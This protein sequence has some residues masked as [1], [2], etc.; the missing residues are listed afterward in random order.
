MSYCRTTIV[1]FNSEKDA[2]EAS[3]DYSKN[4]T[5]EFPDAEILLFTRTGHLSAVVSSVYP[6]DETTYKEMVARKARMEKPLIVGKV[7]GCIK[8]N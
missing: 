6:D 3:A 2:D 4:A 5:S 1:E 8:V 7:S